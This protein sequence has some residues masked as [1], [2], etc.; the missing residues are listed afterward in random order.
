MKNKILISVSNGGQH[1]YAKKPFGDIFG[2]TE[3]VELDID[4]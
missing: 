3:K 1:I 4:S 2:E